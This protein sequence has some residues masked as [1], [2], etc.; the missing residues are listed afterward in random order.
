[1]DDFRWRPGATLA[2][3]AAIALAVPRAHAG[4][5]SERVD[6]A[7]MELMRDPDARQPLDEDEVQKLEKKLFEK[8]DNI[9]ARLRLLN[10]YR[11]D[12][13]ADGRA[14]RSVHVL[15]FIENAPE[16]DVAGGE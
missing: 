3:A 1:N 14:A 13:T 16:S 10:H 8:P 6:E 4:S 2:L 12:R 9:E 15:W 11:M 5:L 7:R